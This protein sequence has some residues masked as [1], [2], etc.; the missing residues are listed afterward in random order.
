M[1]QAFENTLDLINGLKEL[2]HNI[3]QYTEKLLEQENAKEILVQL[4]DNYGE[5]VLGKH[6]YRLKTSD[7]IAKYRMKIITKAR[8][9]RHNNE[10]IK[11]QAE[12]MVQLGFVRDIIDGEN[13]LY[14]WLEAIENAFI[15][16]FDLLTE[17]DDKNRKYHRAA[18]AQVNFHLSFVV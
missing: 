9:Y 16:I 8:E 15:N 1:Q 13:Q 17:I 6:Y 4:F 18:F 2:N 14:D 7:N 10:I 5:Q 12:R 3:K 11:L